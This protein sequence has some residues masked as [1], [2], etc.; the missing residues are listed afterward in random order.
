VFLILSL[1]DAACGLIPGVGDFI[2]FCVMAIFWLIPCIILFDIAAYVKIFV[3]LIVDAIVGLIPGFG[4]IADL[5]PEF[6]AFVP[7]I[8]GM[9]PPVAVATAYRNKLPVLEQ[10]LREKYDQ[11]IKEVREDSRNK[12]KNVMNHFR[13]HFSGVSS[14]NRKVMFLFLFGIIAAIGPMGMG[15]LQIPGTMANYMILGAFVLV[16]TLLQ[17]GHVLKTREVTGLIFFLVFVSLLPYIL[18]YAKKAAPFLGYDT[19]V[20]LV[21]FIVFSLLFIAKSMGWISTSGITKWA[22]FIIFLL[23]IPFLFGYFSSGRATED[24]QTNIELN[25]Q[26]AEELNLLEVLINWATFQEARG[27]GELSG[28]GVQEQTYA[29]IGVTL[30]GVTPSRDQYRVGQ[31]IDLTIDYSA[32]SFNDLYLFTECTIGDTP[33]DVPSE[34]LHISGASPRRVACSFD[35]TGMKPGTHT[36]RIRGIYEYDSTVGLP[37]KIMSSNYANYLAPPPITYDERIQL[38]SDEVNGNE[39]VETSSGPITILVSNT[40]VNSQDALRLPFV[41]DKENPNE[42][43]YLL[44]FVLTNPPTLEQGG[45][46]GMNAITF[47]TPT[48]ITLE[49]CNLEGEP[50]TEIISDRIQTTFLMEGWDDLTRI[51]CEMFIDKT[52]NNLIPETGFF[53]DTL[54]VS[55]K[56]DHAVEKTELIK[57]VA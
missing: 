15:L 38:L 13:G 52:K 37:L 43:P 21:L 57:V 46:L 26:R 25:K 31:P 18:D 45:I 32:N 10:K 28:S 51:T 47:N 54:Y 11:K 40:K 3:F 50:T 39:L 44:A 14:E 34:P 7:G 55:V 19:V 42:V 53:D 8:N 5:A 12:L 35:T 24:F 20:S 6:L 41:V 29:F 33:A 22:I 30:E 9:T 27:S 2:A 36:A 23:M 48:G 1:V 4:D 16:L 49:N 17:L 56:Y